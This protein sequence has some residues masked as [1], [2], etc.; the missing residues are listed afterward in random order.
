MIVT[1]VQFTLAEP[2]ALDEARS[3]FGANA[4]SYLDVPGL[5]FKAYLRSE[6]GS[7]AG[8]VYWWTDRASA[9]AKFD[10]SWLAGVTEKYGSAPT[11]EWFDAPV[12][13]DPVIGVV[14]VDPPNQ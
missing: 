6:D 9:E 5:L 10:Q 11:I 14:R 12:V 2:V 8:G 7:R 4:T 13:V 3:R 1:I